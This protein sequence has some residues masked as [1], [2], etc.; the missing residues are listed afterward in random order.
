MMLISLSVIGSPFFWLDPKEPKGQGSHSE[1]Y[2]LGRYAKIS[3][4]SPSAQTAE[5]F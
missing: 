2:G 4:N 5:I 1:G 3:E